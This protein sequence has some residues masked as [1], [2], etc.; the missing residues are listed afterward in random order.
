M[1]AV[2]ERVGRKVHSQERISREEAL[3]LFE[4]RDVVRLYQLA[5]EVKRKRWGDRVHFVINRQIN[6]SNICVLSCRFC[7]F[8][9]KR[10]RDNA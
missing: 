1:E 8:A 2:L 7:D 5:D 6:P 9:T 4:V 3:G 10:G